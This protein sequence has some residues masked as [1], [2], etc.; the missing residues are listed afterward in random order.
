RSAWWGSRGLPGPGGP[1]VA[2]RE[3]TL[4]GRSSLSSSRDSSSAAA[5]THQAR[6]G[7]GERSEPSDTAGRVVIHRD[8]YALIRHEREHPDGD[9]VTASRWVPSALVSD[10]RAW[11]APR[12]NPPDSPA[13]HA[14]ASRRV[15]R[16]MG[17]C[18][19]IVAID[20]LVSEVGA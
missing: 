5:V 8:V 13:S 4:R 9:G 16:P 20:D 3:S 6:N 11:P 19:A 18:A 1:G 10:N 17:T 14:H 7:H 12:G 2:P 15:T